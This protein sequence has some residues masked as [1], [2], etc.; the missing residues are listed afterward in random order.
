MPDVPQDYSVFFRTT[1]FTAV[2]RRQLDCGCCVLND[3]ALVVGR[4]RSKPVNFA[5][6]CA[7]TC[8]SS[9]TDMDSWKLTRTRSCRERSSWWPQCLHAGYADSLK[10]GESRL[11]REVR[12][13][14]TQCT[15]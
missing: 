12:G 5:L 4:G 14:H 9:A 6:P 11:E 13:L 2:R 15:I 3:M 1:A 10:E 7:A 8:V